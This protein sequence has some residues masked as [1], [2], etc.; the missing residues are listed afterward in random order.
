MN[1]AE[2]PGGGSSS[3]SAYAKHPDDRAYR[4]RVLAA[5]KAVAWLTFPAVFVAMVSAGAG[6]WISDWAE[7]GFLDGEIWEGFVLAPLHWAAIAAAGAIALYSTVI[8]W[9]WD[10]WDQEVKY[11]PMSEEFAQ[12]EAPPG[13]PALSSEHPGEE[14]ERP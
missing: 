12:G 14:P 5:W 3:G 6:E 7:R 11:I 10:A 1:D 8:K 2:R 9:F 4:V 13:R